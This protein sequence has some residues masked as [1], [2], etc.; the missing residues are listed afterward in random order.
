MCVAVC[1]HKNISS[2]AVFEGIEE[3]KGKEAEFLSFIYLNL[4]IEELLE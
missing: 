4:S 1:S 3:D 2:L